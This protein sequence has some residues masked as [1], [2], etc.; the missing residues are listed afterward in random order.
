MKPIKV[1][2]KHFQS[3]EDLE[4]EIKGFTCITG[5]GNIGKS[6]IIRAI[7]KSATNEPVSKMVR[8]GHKHST[9]ELRGEDWGYKW[10]KGDGSVNRY[11]IN[12]TVFDKT[13]QSQLQE[14]SEM[15]FGSISI[16]KEDVYPWVA[17]QNRP[18]FL[19]DRTGSQIT[20][21]ISEFNNLNNLQNYIQF[22][23]KKKKATNDES[24]SIKKEIQKLHEKDLKIG[25]TF[26]VNEII[27]EVEEQKESIL[28]FEKNLENA[29]TL[30]L[31]HKSLRHIVNKIS[32]SLSKKPSKPNID[33]SVYLKAVGLKS[34][35]DKL[36]GSLSKISQIENYC[37]PE[38]PNL[39]EIHTIN[40]FKKFQDLNSKLK[41][42]SGVES[43]ELPEKV[44]MDPKISSLKVLDKKKKF[45]ESFLGRMKLIEGVSF[46]EK[47]IS[48]DVLRESK[49]L[50]TKR[51]NYIREMESLDKEKAELDKKLAD[52][53]NEIKNIP[54]CDFCGR[55][56]ISHNH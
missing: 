25:N 53:K 27:K 5:K 21:F 47:N 46:T 40:K 14:I 52:I 50:N 24:N 9:V 29:K 42:I 32:N 33:A 43:L 44:L 34:K 26:Q 36:L 13:G 55:V 11:T 20:D 6:A 56:D 31:R 54:K 19:M 49:K 4:F 1:K 23:L 10:E 8:L 12:D 15:G 18:L 30:W 35:K 51:K 28:E 2:I 41:K 38:K 48:L 17:Y 22:S 39:K 16:G 45:L 3:I 37:S 7:S